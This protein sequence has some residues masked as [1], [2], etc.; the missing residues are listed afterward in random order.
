MALPELLEGSLGCVGEVAVGPG[1]WNR[2]HAE[3]A[4]PT[5]LG[6]SCLRPLSWLL[7]RNAHKYKTDFVFRMFWNLDSKGC[8]KASLWGWLSTGENHTGAPDQ[9]IAGD[10]PP[11]AM[12]QHWGRVGSGPGS[13]AG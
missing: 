8:I 9:S 13:A 12:C 11:N 1:S 7:P 4:R 2:K 3:L 6:F 5:D 10:R